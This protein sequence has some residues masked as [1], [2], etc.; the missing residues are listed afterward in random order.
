[1]T[2]L[3]PDIALSHMLFLSERRATRYPMSMPKKHDDPL[4]TTPR[5][6]T[7]QVAEMLGIKRPTVHSAIQRGTLQS[8][9]ASVGVRLISQAEIDKYRAEH[10]GQVGKP[11][12]KKRRMTQKA[13]ARTVA[14]A[15]PPSNASAAARGAPDADDV[16]EP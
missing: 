5:F 15:A 14:A 2:A 9:L 13:E 12:R 3:T 11:S 6:T 10:L 1:M 16:K 7:T 4:Y 8:E